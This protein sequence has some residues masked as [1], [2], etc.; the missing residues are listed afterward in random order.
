MAVRNQS[1]GFLD[2]H[3]WN[4]AAQADPICDC[5]VSVTLPSAA[6]AALPKATVRRIDEDHANPLAAWIAMGAPDYTT[7]AQNAQLLEASKLQ[8]EQLAA[9]AKVAADGFSLRV[10]AHGAAVARVSLR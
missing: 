7:A 3:L 2:I 8:T 9:V 1:A 10:P 4:H 6:A 5:T